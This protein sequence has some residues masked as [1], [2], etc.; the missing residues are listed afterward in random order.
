[1]TTTT[2][3]RPVRNPRLDTTYVQIQDAIDAAA[4][5]DVLLVG[6]GVYRESLRF[7]RS[8]SVVAENERQT[9]LAPR[10]GWNAIASYGEHRVVVKGFEIALS[11]DSTLLAS[12][13]ADVSFVGCHVQGHGNAL[14]GDLGPLAQL[15]LIGTL[16]SDLGPLAVAVSPSLSLVPLVSA[17][18]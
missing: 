3:D 1:M 13:I 2:P 14:L 11:G 7:D 10:P 16:V 18:A 8:V 4:S 9:R 15:R 12:D 6:P 5:G 17:V